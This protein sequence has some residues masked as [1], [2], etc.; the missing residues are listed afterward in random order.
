MDEASCVALIKGLEKRKRHHDGEVYYIHTSGTSNF[1][2]HPISGTPV[3]ITRSDE[4][5]IFSWEKENAKGWVTRAVDVAVIEAGE[6]FGVRTVIVNPP[7]IYGKGK[8]PLHQTSIQIPALIKVS[9]HF[10]QAVVLGDGHGVRPSSSSLCSSVLT[11]L[12]QVWNYI[13]INDVSSFYCHLVQ[14]ILDNRPLHFGKTGYYFIESGQVSWRDISE[15]IAE[16]G[17]TQG[18]L[19]KRNLRSLS[20]E[21][22]CQALGISFLKPSM[23]EVIWASK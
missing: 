20:P 17:L 23:V 7:I 14:L 8:G 19:D 6:K 16:V 10:K 18:L 22:M 1:G 15:R 5:D 21:E 4:D 11:W 13:H 3:D 2:D 12:N 9:L